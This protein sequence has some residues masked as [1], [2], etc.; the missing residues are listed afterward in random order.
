M[1][2][3]V[4]TVAKVASLARIRV[5]SDE[6]DKYSRELSGILK[7]IEMLDNVNTDSVE[8]L[9]NVANIELK[10]REDVVSDGNYQQAV[11]KNAPESLQGY[12]AV[13]KVIE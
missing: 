2:M 5:E 10:Q 1:S 12:F 8:P 7:W 3:D 6:L 11:L 4:K 13:P 9:A